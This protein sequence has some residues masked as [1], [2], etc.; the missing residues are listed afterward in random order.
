MGT[1]INQYYR[2]ALEVL[3]ERKEVI[4][5]TGDERKLLDVLENRNEKDVKLFL[6]ENPSFNYLILMLQR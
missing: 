6:Q 5:L 2:N 3:L 1:F 4:A